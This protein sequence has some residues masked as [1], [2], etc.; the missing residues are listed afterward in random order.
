MVFQRKVMVALDEERPTNIWALSE[1][2]GLGP[3][4]IERFGEDLLQM[5]EQHAD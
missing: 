2:H 5:I 4:K 3:A 1:I